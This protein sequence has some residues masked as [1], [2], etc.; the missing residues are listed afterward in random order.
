MTTASNLSH[1]AWRATNDEMVGYIDAAEAH[2]AAA[3]A[4]ASEGKD[5]LSRAHQREAARLRRIVVA[6][7]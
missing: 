3:I 5:G 4:C 6:G 1:A 2:D 7:R